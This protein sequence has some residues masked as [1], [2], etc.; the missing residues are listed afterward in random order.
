MTTKALAA[1]AAMLTSFRMICSWLGIKDEALS[2]A[3]I[4]KDSGTGRFIPQR[5]MLAC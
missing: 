4:V 3:H 1:P 2:G 5:A